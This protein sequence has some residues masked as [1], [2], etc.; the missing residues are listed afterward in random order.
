MT[1]LSLIVYYYY[2]K[3]SILCSILDINECESAPCMNNGTCIDEVNSYSCECM[4][5]YTGS[6]CETGMRLHLKYLSARITVNVTNI[7]LFS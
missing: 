3:A 5:G 2:H 7:M 4:P 1:S 6:T